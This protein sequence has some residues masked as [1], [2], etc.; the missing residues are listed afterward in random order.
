VDAAIAAMSEPNGPT[1]AAVQDLALPHIQGRPKATPERVLRLRTALSQLTEVLEKESVTED[2]ATD[3]ESYL[4]AISQ[5]PDLF[6]SGNCKA[7]GEHIRNCGRLGERFVFNKEVMVQLC[8]HLWFKGRELVA[9]EDTVNNRYL[10]FEKSEFLF[11][12]Q[13]S[14]KP[15]AAVVW[16]NAFGESSKPYDFQVHLLHGYA[17]DDRLRWLEVKTT[18]HA[19]S[20][21]DFSV[22]QWEFAKLKRDKFVL[23]LVGLPPSPDCGFIQCD[24]DPYGKFV[25]GRYRAAARLKIPLQQPDVVLL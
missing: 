6:L 2:C 17:E 4:A 23:V 21:A 19:S 20:I 9:Q 10:L 25:D 15:L 16:E 1:L 14:L 13:D 12:G 18:K 3:I 7:I 5:H 8:T 24:V 22:A 11:A